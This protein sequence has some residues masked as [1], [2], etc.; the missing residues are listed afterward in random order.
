MSVIQSLEKPLGCEAENILHFGFR[1]QPE[2][3]S[4]RPLQAIAIVPCQ[5]S[6]REVPG[7]ISETAKSAHPTTAQQQ[8]L[9]SLALGRDSEMQL[10][11][12]SMDS[13]SSGT[14]TT[15]F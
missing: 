2:W 12:F 14:Q 8:Y 15:A 3:N 1:S 13:L 11:L 10:P 7:Q 5:L 6:S 4:V 9:L